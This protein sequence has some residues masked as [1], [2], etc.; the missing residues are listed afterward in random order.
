MMTQRFSRTLLLTGVFALIAPLGCGAPPAREAE[1]LS[2]VRQALGSGPDFVVR[3]VS[4]PSSTW[5]GGPLP[6]TVTVCNQGADGD[7]TQVDVF[8]S[9]DPTVSSSDALIS[10]MFLGWLQPGRCVTDTY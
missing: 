2:P 7:S 6:V 8:L 3:K 10:N 5:P 1:G 4:A 9:S